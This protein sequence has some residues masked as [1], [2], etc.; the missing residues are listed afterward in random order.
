MVVGALG[1]EVHG[2]RE[3]NEG[4]VRVAQLAVDLPGGGDGG[5]E[6]LKI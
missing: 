3:V 4:Q 2:P 1:V 6:K 5:G